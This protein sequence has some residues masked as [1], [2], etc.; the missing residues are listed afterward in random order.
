MLFKIFHEF[1]HRSQNMTLKSQ[2]LV[3]RLLVIMCVGLTITTTKVITFN[4]SYKQKWFIC[5]VIPVN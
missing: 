5:G 1:K 2:N 3:F 4:K